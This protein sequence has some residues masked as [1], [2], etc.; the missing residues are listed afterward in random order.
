MPNS[1][2][3][4]YLQWVKLGEKLI[5]D[6]KEAMAT[7]SPADE[8]AQKVAAMHGQWLSYTMPNYTKQVHAN[9][10]QTYVNDER[11]AAYYEAAGPNA[12]E[13]L[14]DAILIHCQNSSIST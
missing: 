1:H 9:L 7:G 6:L 10:V 2:D 13:F 5:V 4:N 14:R 12:A 3:D 11:F 8:S